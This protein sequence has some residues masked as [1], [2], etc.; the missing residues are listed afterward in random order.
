MID[1]EIVRDRPFGRPCYTV[2][3]TIPYHTYMMNDVII[4]RCPGANGFEGVYSINGQRD[5]D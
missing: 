1:F 2:Y 5:T 3:S 4:L